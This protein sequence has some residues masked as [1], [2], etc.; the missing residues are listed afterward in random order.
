[1]NED[2]K[3]KIFCERTSIQ[4]VQVKL[5]LGI[6]E[7]H[8]ASTIID[9]RL[10][11]HSED[12]E[13][14]IAAFKKWVDLCSNVQ[15]AE[16]AFTYAKTPEQHKMAMKKWIELCK[17]IA[18]AR[19]VFNEAPEGSELEELSLKKWIE[20]CTT[21]SE[22]AKAYSYVGK[23]YEATLKAIRKMYELSEFS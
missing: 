3:L 1:M 9:A 16:E 2:E 17:T 8:A 14:K 6:L 5:A 4:P 12:D 10:A 23:H 19:V 13:V 20:L 21:Y 22:V 11:C 7:P 15:E 18:E